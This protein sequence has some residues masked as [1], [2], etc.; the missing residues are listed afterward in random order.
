M[1]PQ[2]PAQIRGLLL[3]GAFLRPRRFLYAV[4]KDR[5]RGAV[6]ARPPPSFA[7]R[8]G[9]I[10]W[11]AQGRGMGFALVGQVSALTRR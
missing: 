9:M 4:V 3:P 6:A 1:Y 5:M 8:Q 10:Y 11:S 7:D 2:T